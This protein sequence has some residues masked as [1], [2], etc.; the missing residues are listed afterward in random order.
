[1]SSALSTLMLISL[2][3]R[4]GASWREIL[5]CHCHPSLF[6]ALLAPPVL[7][8]FVYLFV[9]L[10]CICFVF[11]FVFACNNRQELPPTGWQASPPPSRA[12]LA[13]GG[14]QLQAHPAPF[15]FVF[16]CFEY[17][18]LFWIFVFVFYV[19]SPAWPAL[20]MHQR[21]VHTACMQ[22]LRL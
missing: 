21:L 8:L 5:H 10:F 1:M 20:E 13:V 14:K 6:Q 22:G 17:L 7:Y 2:I 9:Y 12:Q 16:V 18:Y 11:V 3:K 4:K 15:V 19:F